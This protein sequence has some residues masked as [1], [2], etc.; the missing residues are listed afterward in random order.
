MSIATDGS[1]E[2]TEEIS[3]AYKRQTGARAATSKPLRGLAA[4]K[5]FK[6][7]VDELARRGEWIPSKVKREREVQAAQDA[8]QRRDTREHLLFEK[9]WPQFLAD[10]DDQGDGYA[11]RLDAR[12]AFKRLEKF[13][14][15]FYLDQITAGDVRR[16]Y[17]GA[18]CRCRCGGRHIR[19]TL[20]QQHNPDGHLDRSRGHDVAQDVLRA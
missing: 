13:W 10:L 15:G 3:Q 1:Q 2:Y 19:G 7:D 16:F 4:A 20:R 12:S 14:R 9:A 17:G 5:R 8:K 6:T 11:N 18:A